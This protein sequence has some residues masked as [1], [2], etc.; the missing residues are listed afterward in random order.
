MT[1]RARALVVA[2]AVVSGCTL[3]FP[4]ELALDGGTPP[5]DAGP[6]PEGEPL[7]CA[8]TGTLG[9]VGTEPIP[10]RPEYPGGFAVDVA[11]GDFGGDGPN[12]GLLLKEIGLGAT[13]GDGPFIVSFGT[14]SCSPER[15]GESAMFDGLDRRAVDRA[16]VT[17]L[18][19]ATAVV[20]LDDEGPPTIATLARGAIDFEHAAAIEGALAAETALRGAAAGDV[21][22]DGVVDLVL[23]GDDH[24]TVL[25]L[26]LGAGDPEHAHRIE[27]PHAGRAVLADFDRDGHLDLLAGPDVGTAPPAPAAELRGA[28]LLG[29]GAGAF[30]SP[31]PLDTLA[32]MGPFAVLD[33]D[34]DGDP[35]L[36]QWRR[37]D[38]ASG[39]EP[40][41]EPVLEL[42]RNASSAG[43][44]SFG[45][46]IPIAGDDARGETPLAGTL[47][48][49]DLD[50]DGWVDA[51]TLGTSGGVLVARGGATPALVTLPRDPARP[52]LS[53]MPAPRVAIGDAD[54]DGD[55]DLLALF[56]DDV[57]T[58]YRFLLGDVG[59]ARAIV[60]RLSG[61]AIAGSE[62]CLAPVG[63][64][65]ADGGCGGTADV[66]LAH[67]V[68]IA[69]TVQR[70]YGTEIV[71]GVPVPHDV[72]DLRVLVRARGGARAHDVAGLRAGNRYALELGPR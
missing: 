64:L 3:E 45:A 58:Y 46:P 48:V 43:S 60:V 28:V 66:I 69:S 21:D 19:G 68:S 39:G 42:L 26:G 6:P 38:E 1:R 18:D 17:D 5:L 47:A 4:I 55:P 10:Q 25:R 22:G 24:A 27:L 8:G 51:T 54:H 63:A 50:L 65:P 9:F 29:D 59:A 36:V 12:E 52:D 14:E 15:S 16:W 70:G 13:K 40:F 35:D 30:G 11:F 34:R 33:V 41:G 67:H 37:P 20:A 49:G 62:A 2:I 32:L 53:S 7:A 61:V 57:N 44:V 71:L 31:T 72:V 56:T 23:V